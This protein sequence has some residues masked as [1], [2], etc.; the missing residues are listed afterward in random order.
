[1]LRICSLFMSGCVCSGGGSAYTCISDDALMDS[2]EGLYICFVWVVSAPD[3]NA[4]DQMW[5]DVCV[6]LFSHS[7]FV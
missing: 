1:M 5:I 6:V 2:D 4:A 7:I 3:G